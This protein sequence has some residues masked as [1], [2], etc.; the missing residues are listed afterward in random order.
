MS[1]FRSGSFVPVSFPGFVPDSAC[2]GFGLNSAPFGYVCRMSSAHEPEPAGEGLFELGVRSLVLCGLGSCALPKCCLSKFQR[3]V[4]HLHGA[5]TTTPMA[6]ITKRI[7]R[8]VLTL[9]VAGLL[10]AALIRISPGW[11]VDE[12]ELD[13]RYS[14]QTI[15]A[16]RHDR[17]D[18]GNLL[19][20]YA[21]FLV[22]LTR[23]DAGESIV[24]GRPV[25]ALISERLPMTV[26][27]VAAGL[28]TGWCAALL[29][30]AATALRPN[31]I[32]GLG[33]AALTG[34]L[35]SVPSAV[36]AILCLL[37]GF[38]P[39]A[40]VAA[41]V[42]PRVYP[43]AYEQF[44]AALRR[45]HVILGR[46]RG[47]SP[48]RLFFWHVLPSA[49]GPL[50]ALAGVS[51]ALAFGASIPIEALTDSPG[52][53]QLAWRAALGRDLPVLVAITLLL[54]AVTIIANLMSD[55]ALR[56]IRVTLI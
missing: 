30:A 49:L 43:H 2:P 17:A 29:I 46:A 27:S 34:G 47:L 5:G 41:V 54:A 53:G 9:F 51:I 32:T 7:V 56:R 24:F 37:A 45:P 12:Q 42:F 39:G 55:L 31:F 26:R 4:L 44:R 16:M 22:R 38:P 40:A 13:P 33:A 23:G 19:A 50:M 1:R 6:V 20:F 18:T 3:D 52:V 14:R 10:G 21:G 15:E 11:G 35:L 8:A 25:A 48:A 28:G 36:L